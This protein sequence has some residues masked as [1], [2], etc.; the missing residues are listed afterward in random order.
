MNPQVDC[1]PESEKSQLSKLPLTV[2]SLLSAYAYGW[3]KGY[4]LGQQKAHEHYNR[5]LRGEYGK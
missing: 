2:Q 3:N 5:M 1:K 4:Q